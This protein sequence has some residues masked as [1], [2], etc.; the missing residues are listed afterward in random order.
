MSK[1]DKHF[2]WSIINKKA[3]KW[4][5]DRGYKI[6]PKPIEF[7]E[8]K[9]KQKLGVKFKLVVEYGS[10]KKEGSKEY[11]QKEWP[12]AIWSVY[13]YLYNKHSGSKD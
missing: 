11:T 7:K 13:N 9:Y 8:L 5:F 4:C 6:Y 2:Q 12:I 1:K 10:E 3:A